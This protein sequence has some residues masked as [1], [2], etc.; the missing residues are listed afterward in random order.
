MEYLI[1]TDSVHTTAAACDY[2]ELRLDPD[3]TVAVVTVPS[4]DDR[5][6]DDA[7][8]VANARLLGRAEV[9]VERLETQTDPESAI[10]T[11]AADRSPDVLIIGPHA[12]LP[13]AGP[14]LGETA[15]TVIEKADIPVVVVPL[16]F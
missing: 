16:S 15:R 13:E 11:A 2:L 1:A 6:G 4:E 9:E 10:L 3:D 12:G 7:L 8:N 5:D 14:A